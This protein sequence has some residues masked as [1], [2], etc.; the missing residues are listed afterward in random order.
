MSDYYETAQTAEALDERMVLMQ[1]Y[2]D[3]DSARKQMDREQKFL[4]EKS[5]KLAAEFRQVS[6]RLRNMLGFDDPMAA[7][8]RSLEA[9]V[10]Q[11]RAAR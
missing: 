2:V 3:L 6:E 4:A 9:E 8:K 1:Q 5:H 11:M 10:E 7:A